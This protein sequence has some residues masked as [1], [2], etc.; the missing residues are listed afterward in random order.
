MPTQLEDY[1]DFTSAEDWRLKDHRVG[2]EDVI[3]P[4]L[5]GYAAEEIAANLP[6]VGLEQIHGVMAY[7][8]HNRRQVDEYMRGLAEWR[9]ARYAARLDKPS[10]FRQRL[11]ALRKRL[12]AE[13]VPA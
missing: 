4:Y 5:E 3:L 11:R 2:I 12:E 7:Y 13:A 9:E 8:L 6:E 1:L 10:A